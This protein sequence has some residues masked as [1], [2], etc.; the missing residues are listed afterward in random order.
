MG[1]GANGAAREA[2]APTGPAPDQR[3]IYMPIWER[4]SIPMATSERPYSILIQV[5]GPYSS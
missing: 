2:I 5:P 1:H 4:L 3:A